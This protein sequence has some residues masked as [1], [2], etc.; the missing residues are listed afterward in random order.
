MTSSLTF[1]K[2]FP[3][4][5]FAS[6]FTVAFQSAFHTAFQETCEKL[7]GNVPYTTGTKLS[8]E[9]EARR[10]KRRCRFNIETPDL[11]Y[12]H[13][14]YSSRE[15]GVEDTV[16]TNADLDDEMP[17]LITM[18]EAEA[19]SVL[20]AELDEMA[21]ARHAKTHGHCPCSNC[22]KNTVYP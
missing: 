18:E 21:H 1:P 16:D 7:I 12:N 10:E 8:Y 4:E 2:Q 22:K 6:T 14:L 9:E 20:D 13:P 19:F 17:N 11:S 15:S 3:P 5:L